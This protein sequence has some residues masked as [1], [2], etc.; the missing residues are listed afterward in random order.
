MKHIY[1]YT[2]NSYNHGKW[3]RCPRFKLW[4][5]LIAFPFALF[6]LSKA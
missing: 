3:N 5:Q 2:G 4:R 1:I 6:P